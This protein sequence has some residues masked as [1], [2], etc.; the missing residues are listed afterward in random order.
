M[1]IDMHQPNRAVCRN[2]PHNRQRNGVVTTRAERDNSRMVKTLIEIGYIGMAGFNIKYP[3]EMN[4]ADIGYPAQFI[5]INSR[6]MMDGPH[7]TGHVPYLPGSLA[8]ARSGFDGAIIGHSDQ[9]NVQIVQVGFMRGSH[10]CRDST[11]TRL[12]HGILLVA[13][14]IYQSFV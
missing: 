13:C 3:A 12:I 5:G 8:C 2:R 14:H 4:I 7:H 11:V 1:G 9:S 6:D 10:K